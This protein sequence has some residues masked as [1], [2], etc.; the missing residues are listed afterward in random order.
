[1]AVSLKKNFG[2]ALVGNL[3]YAASQYI[4]LLI[5]IKLYSM[6]DVGQFVYA[7]A[8]TTPLMMALEMQLRNFY[9]T[10]DESVLGF[11]DYISFRTFSSILG[12]F[13]LIL[14]AWFLK[15][16]YFIV[17][18]IVTLIKSFESQLDLI[19]GIY[20]KQHKLNYVAYSRIIRGI[21]A[22][23]VV[24]I[25]SLIFKDIVVSLLAYLFSWILLY[26][27]YER[28]QVVK[29]EFISIDELQLKAI[30]RKTI[31][32]FLV[33]CF[34]VFCAI[35]V[36][37]Y[38]LN[39]PRLSVERFLGIEAVAIFGSLLYFKSLG[40]QFISSI[41]QAAMPRL[42]EYVKS[43][44]K[45]KFLS[46]VLKMV[47][48]GLGLG[49]T[50]TASAYF[51]GSRALEILYTKGYSQYNDVLI[52]VLIGTTITFAY[53]FIT[54]AF[55]ALRKQWIRL[56]VSIVML[57]IIVLLFYYL[58]IDSLLDIA[59]IVLYTELISLFVFYLL[60]IIFINSFFKK[61]TNNL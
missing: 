44:Q 34:P 58:K 5:F 26:F 1:M 42:A 23:V 15:P 20:Q 4:I 37:K 12:I 21:V 17:I 22:V 27:F 53:T 48:I 60:F 31:W 49:L 2:F 10:D 16:E 7:G 57:A 29:R 8:F 14:A 39:Y 50:L 11:R 45:K 40:G 28:K 9:I 56:P 59:Y 47:A 6:D 43:K 38:Y 13:I 41:A 61:T 19:Y 25:I 35:Y 46:L 36:D 24:T 33:L 51:F 32:H 30:N 18:V 55:T 52:I 3:A 54:S